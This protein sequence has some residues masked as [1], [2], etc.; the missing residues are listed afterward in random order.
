MNYV[1]YAFL[2]AVLFA[3]NALVSKFSSKHALN[4]PDGLAAYFLLT[5]FVLIL[6]LLPFVTTRLPAFELLIALA[7]GG[8][9]YAF[10]FYIFFKALA[11]VDASSFSA[12]FQMQAVIIA[13]LAFLF[14]GERFPQANYLWALLI[15]GG[16]TMVTVDESVSL[17]SFFRPAVWLLI[18]MQFF[19][20]VAG[21]SLGY[22]VKRMP[23]LEALVWEFLFMGGVTGLLLMMRRP[24]LVYP[25][26][27]VAP[28]ILAATLNFAG[29]LAILKAFQTNLT[30][31]SVIGLM[32]APIVFLVTLLLA[33]FNPNLLENHTKEI[34]FIRGIGLTMTLFGA[35]RLA[36]G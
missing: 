14:L 19:H 4:D 1:G 32:Q 20:A 13:V 28:I 35:Y 30:I 26:K 3:G 10:G 25:V 23:I 31:S 12:I 2:A 33:R 7:T 15:V 17:K 5:N 22:A 11:K 18:V 34:Y 6:T 27:K 21:L 29:V 9:F 16:A 36:L 24:K 8:V